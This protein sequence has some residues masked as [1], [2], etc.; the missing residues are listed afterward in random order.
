M[1]E[2]ILGLAHEA[3]VRRKHAETIERLKDRAPSTQEEVLAVVE[4]GAARQKRDQISVGF[5]LCNDGELTIRGPVVELSEV[6]PRRV[7]DERLVLGADLPARSKVTQAVIYPGDECEVSGS[8]RQLD[9]QRD[10][11][12]EPGEYVVRWRVFMDNSPPSSG[13]IDLGQALQSAKE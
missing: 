13:E 11:V 4:V 6:R 9:C 3:E 7:T 12:F 2:I 8:K 1:H 10:V 5:V